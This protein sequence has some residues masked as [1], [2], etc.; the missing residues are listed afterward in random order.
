MKTPGHP[1]RGTSSPYRCSHCHDGQINPG[2]G[3]AGHASPPRRPLPK[4]II[5]EIKT[6]VLGS[7]LPSR[8]D[9]DSVCIELV[10][11]GSG[12]EPPQDIQRKQSKVGRRDFH[13]HK[14]MNR[15]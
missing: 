14:T 15:L 1:E 13:S 3:A 7:P 2:A 4:I 5:D 11:L 10:P 8:S 6:R 12:L 9:A